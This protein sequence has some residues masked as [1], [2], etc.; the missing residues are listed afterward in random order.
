MNIC[1]IK[2]KREDILRIAKKYG[3]YNIRI[4]G[5]VVR[6]EAK[7]DSDLDILVDL[8]PDRSL[9]DHAGLIIDLQETMNCKVDVVTE[10]GLRPRIRDVILKEA[11][12][13]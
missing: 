3:A 1:E 4:F 2:E 8:E 5:S 6:G 7:Q 12:P 13:I 10:K 9:L 11:I